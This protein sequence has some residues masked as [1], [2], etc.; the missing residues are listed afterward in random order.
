MGWTLEKPAAECNFPGTPDPDTFHR[1]TMDSYAPAVDD[2]TLSLSRLISVLAEDAIFA[3]AAG[4]GANSLELLAKRRGEAYS[5]VLAG[6]RIHTMTSEFDPWLVTLTRAMAP[7]SPPIAMPMGDVIREGITL[8]VGARG[9]RSLFSSKPSEKEVL[10][11]KRL[12]TLAVRTLRAVMAADGNI[13]PEEAR[14]IAAVLSS[15]GLPEGE[16][17]PLYTEAPIPI[18]Q[19]DMYGEIEQNVANALVRG[20]W[21]GAA[22]DEIDPREEQVVRTFAGKMS[23]KPETVEQLRNEAIARVDARRLVGLATT[24][25]LR[26]VLSDR[27]TGTGQLLGVKTAELLLP[28]RYRDEAIG[29]ITHKVPTT[30]GRRYANLSSDDKQAALG[31][32][33]A[34]AS[35]EDPTQSRRALLRA[36]HDRFA[37]DLGDD[38]ARARQTVEVWINEVLAPAAFPMA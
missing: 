4:G 6:H 23:M 1:M 2:K 25:G 37:Q 27:L 8:E 33:W 15:L 26:Y 36:R 28:K 3:F 13:D 31:I 16:T 11:V 38:G 24:D 18:A 20:A 29:P 14:T 34:A 7:I 12:G 21:L 32:T 17:N 19:T 9:L 22:V 5:A 35:W 10:R 30:L